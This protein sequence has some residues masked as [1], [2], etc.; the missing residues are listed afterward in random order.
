MK[1]RAKRNLRKVIATFLLIGM[2]MGSFHQ[3]TYAAELDVTAP[4][5]QEQETVEGTE[6][7]AGEVVSETAEG[8]EQA[9][10][11]VVSE[12]AESTE[13]AA[14][15]IV[16]EAAESTEQAVEE[17]ET[18]EVTEPVYA[19][20]TQF[21]ADGFTVVCELGSSWDGGYNASV[22]LYNNGTAKMESWNLVFEHKNEIR[23]I[24]NAVI[25]EQENGT[26]FVTND[27]WNQD[28]AVNGFVEFGFT[29][30]GNFQGFPEAFEMVGGIGSQSDEKYA[31]DYRISSEWNT[32][33]NAEITI[34]NNTEEMLEDW[35]LEFDYDREITNIWNGQIMDHKNNHYVI[36]N[37]GYNSNI[38]AGETVSFGFSGN[39]GTP[40]DV[41]SDCKI[42]SF[43]V[44]LE[45][46]GK[47]FEEFIAE[48]QIDSDGDGLA[49]ALEKIYGT[50]AAKPDT[51]EDGLTDYEELYVTFTDPLKADT[52]GDGISD[53]SDDADGDGLTN[54]EEFKLG[55]DPRNPDS[56]Q[57]G[58]SDYE[59]VNR[60][61]TDPLKEDTDGD[62]V[63]DG[64]EVEMGTDPLTANT[65]FDAV[66]TASGEDSV[67]VSTKVKLKG[68]QVDSL[69]VSRYE[70]EFLFPEEMPGYIGGIY[71][72]QAE[73]AF[74]EAQLIFEFDEALLADPEFD[75]VIYYFNEEEQELEALDTVI[76]NNIATA[77][78]THF[79]KYMLLNRKVFESAFE[80]ED[81]WDAS[82]YSDVE[83]VL[84]V[85]DSGSMSWN[86]GSNQRLEV[87]RTLIEKLPE[88]AKIGVV[89]FETKVELLTPQLIT[90]RD[91]A[92]AFMTTKYFKSSGGTYM[93]TA[94]NKAFD[95][96]ES[97]AEDTLKIM[98]VLSDG[99]AHDRTQHSATIQAA[100][101]HQVKLY[102]VGL[103]TGSSTYFNNYLKPMAENTGAKFYLT[104]NA[105]GLSEIFK[106]IN[107]KIDIETDSDGDGI[108]DY[109]EENLQLFNG[110]K[111]VLNKNN[112]DSDSDGLTD[113]IEVAEIKYS[114]NED[115]TKA[116]VTG[117]VKA[118]PIL[119]DSDY[120]GIGD[121]SDP[122]PL[123]NK[124]TGFMDGYVDVQSAEYTMDFRK[125]FGDKTKYNSA[126]S[127]ASLILVNNIYDGC[128]FR[129]QSGASGTAST[130]E[131]I[132]QL[133]GFQNVE[134]YKS[135]SNYSDDDVSEISIGVREETYQGVTKKI[136][137]VVI[138]GTNGTVREWSS[139]FD[140]GNPR[141]WNS[142]YHK[143]FYNTEERLLS[144]VNSY[145]SRNIS[146][147]SNLL[148]WVTGHSRGAALANI[149]AAR[150]IDQGKEVVAYTFATPNTTISSS[151]NAQKYKSIFN[152]CNKMDMVTYMPLNQ[153][154]F[155]T[156]GQNY[157]VDVKNDGLIPVWKTRTGKSACNALD[158]QVVQ[159][160]MNQI[161]SRCAS[162]W[163]GAFEY[164]GDQYI[165][166]SEYNKVS[167]RQ[168]RYCKIEE[169]KLFSWHLG[170][171]LYPSLSYICQL[172]AEALGDDAQLR[173]NAVDLF[174]EFWNSKYGVALVLALGQSI[175]NFDVSWPE[176]LG[177]ELV[178][179]A[180]A[181][182]T[183]YVIIHD[184]Y[185]SQY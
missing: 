143:G 28:V 98:L 111:L 104:S 74:D 69:E 85:D 162:S 78:T 71:E 90:D 15:E 163:A 121:A 24:W 21:T 61:G 66:A 48:L 87:A 40:S 11:E 29:C 12:A 19:E 125:F 13:Q 166:D 82:G 27:Q 4:E 79:S 33:F 49:D 151:V 42:R 52:D 70:D 2:C 106:D 174:P 3:Y 103:G 44:E 147:T 141:N 76:E 56:D 154:G 88:D 36:G 9:A 55:T 136:L 59:E 102:T 164:A 116:I 109:Y 181:P 92:K 108:S 113:G 168:K 57:D 5:M 83:L 128:S 75:P 165:S 112:P 37:C 10:E 18:A 139:N 47:T 132:L 93:Y 114:C 150:L 137:A 45:K 179:D 100:N 127:S 77:V 30:A 149:M 38:K 182:A 50:D 161:N 67:K 140:M 86:D 133:H 171:K 160:T 17:T 142:V 80:W 178:G 43:S 81:V 101:N 46:E 60:Y 31:V 122:A 184:S 148:Y 175:F 62:S 99:D 107:K 8:T 89:R 72:F 156:F 177:E 26:Y 119:A 157:F 23:S 159:N 73:G 105:D 152:I 118:N 138:R 145:I 117:K 68:E 176:K 84:V 126:I 20:K 91:A 158:S 22:K 180:H 51:D 25:K 6:Q 131:A 167:Y 39:G 183:Y 41:P 170:Y 32:G 14:E 124:F 16:S 123:S 120:D 58:L 115:R 97:D 65:Y 64:K 110:V 144:Y 53:L 185:L 169:R 95:L 153:W 129:Y 130:A 173:N 96:F 146:D 7:A 1:K 34:Q 94:I 63:S 172:G 135:S 134:N 54:A 35:V 155:N